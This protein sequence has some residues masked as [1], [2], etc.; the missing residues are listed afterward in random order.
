MLQIKRID[1]GEGF[2]V[3]EI[4]DIA[5]DKRQL[6]MESRCSDDGI[7]Q[8]DALISPNINALLNDGFCKGLFPELVQ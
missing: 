2:Y 1:R 7:G 4:A 8:F 3:F 6:K 5:S